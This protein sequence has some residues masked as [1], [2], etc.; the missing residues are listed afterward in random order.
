MN[1]FDKDIR[2]DRNGEPL[3]GRIYFLQKDTNQLDSIY[4]YDEQNNL[5]PCN[6]PV[7][8]NIN[9]FLEYDVI[10][11]NRIYSIKQERYLGNLDDPKSDTKPSSWEDDRWY[12]AGFSI[13]NGKEDTVVYGYESI[14]HADPSIGTLTVIGYHNDFDCGAR[15]YVWDK[16]ATD[17][18]DFGQIFKSNVQNTGRWVLVNSLPYI[19]SEYYGVYPGHLE[20]L[21]TLFG[22][23]LLYGSDNKI[24]SPKAIKMHRG[25]Y[26][27]TSNV[28]TSRTLLLED[29]IDFGSTYQVTCKDVKII[30]SGNLKKP[31]GNFKFTGSDVT[32]DSYIFY[33]LFKMLYSGAKTIHIYDKQA[34]QVAER[35]AAITCKDMTFISHG[36]LTIPGHYYITLDNCHLIGDKLFGNGFY[37]KF[38]NMEVTDKTF[39]DY[40]ASG[41]IDP[42]T[43]SIH[44]DNFE[45]PD[46]YVYAAMHSFDLSEIDLQGHTYAVDNTQVY[47]IL[48]TKPM[49]FRNGYLGK[50]CAL[51]D[52]NIENCNVHDFQI[53]NGTVNF[54]NCNI[55]KVSYENQGVI[56]NFVDCFVHDFD[57]DNETKV[58]L[59]AINTTLNCDIGDSLTQG[60]TG[61]NSNPLLGT[62]RLWKSRVYGNIVVRGPLEMEESFVRDSIWTQDFEEGGFH[63]IRSTM[64]DST[65]CGRHIMQH[66]KPYRTGVRSSCVWI[67]N[68]FS[69]VEKNPIYPESW[70]DP[71]GEGKF[72]KD[73]VTTLYL[74][75]YPKNHIWVYKSN[76]GPKAIPD[77]PTGSY[78]GWFGFGS[79][80]YGGY[81]AF[82]PVPMVYPGHSIKGFDEDGWPITMDYEDV[83]IPNVKWSIRFYRE[84]WWENNH[85]Q[86]FEHNPHNPSQIFE[87]ITNKEYGAVN[88]KPFKQTSYYENSSE[89]YFRVGFR[90]SSDTVS[91]GDW[92]LYGTLDVVDTNSRLV[93]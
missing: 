35:T 56:F 48:N 27:L 54:K 79:K 81:A 1:A 87:A 38:K 45:N 22:A 2:L 6:N 55:D 15:T 39:V 66:Y 46:K 8:T 32:V 75:P 72:T 30:G 57:W 61:D 20:N 60:K 62:L 63:V 83:Y 85:T 47:Q 64:K 89:A 84:L 73:D 86:K 12:Y 5:I 25:V 88:Y 4:T 43:C 17:V 44:I 58:E 34:N 33:D 14:K 51:T 74:D 68:K 49:T 82:E 7:Y 9:G 91:Y 42:A 67:N 18:E 3:H 77:F 93:Y 50:V 28:S 52:V 37:F 26:N 24:S 92:E 41:E 31:I 11:E 71:V 13:E 90:T 23:S 29:E 69:N 21:Q 19:P 10:L 65:I 80:N 53:K 76:R 78:V 16:T 40:F 70:S 59:N 36:T